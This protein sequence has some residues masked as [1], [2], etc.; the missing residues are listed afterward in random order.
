[1]K[2]SKNDNIIFKL[3]VF[4]I[5]TKD[6]K[7]RTWIRH[8]MPCQNDMIHTLT[9]NSSFQKLHIGKNKNLSFNQTFM[10]GKNKF[11]NVNLCYVPLYEVKPV[12]LTNQHFWITY[13][14]YNQKLSIL[15]SYTTVSMR[16]VKPRNLQA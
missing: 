8:L 2:N 13:D 9:K 15:F 11:R 1:M 6:T 14:K 7:E 16:Y 10:I 3:L 4:S 5:S 12:L